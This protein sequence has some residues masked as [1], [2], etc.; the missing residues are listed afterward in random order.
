MLIIRYNVAKGENENEWVSTKKRGVEMVAL[1][2]VY[3][4][5]TRAAP[6]RSLE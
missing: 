4:F 2:R 1:V 5:T 6:F 3:M